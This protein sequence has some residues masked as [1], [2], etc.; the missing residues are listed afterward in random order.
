MSPPYMQVWNVTSCIVTDIIL[1][2]IGYA[3][4]AKYTVL[5]G[6]RVGDKIVN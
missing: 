5:A 3:N 2:P 6:Y 4:S 1:L